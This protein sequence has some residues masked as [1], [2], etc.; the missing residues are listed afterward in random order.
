MLKAD[1]W[2]SRA[3]SLTSIAVL[4]GLVCSVFINSNIV[5]SIAV[6]VVAVFIFKVAVDIFRPAVNQLLDG[7]ADQK[8]QDK[9]IEIAES[10]EG[11]IRVDEI[12]TR[13][14]GNAI[15]ADLEIHVDGS[16]SV[17]QGH[18]IAEEVHDKLETSSELRIKHCNVHVNPCKGHTM[19]HE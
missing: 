11:V 14:F 15:L 1:A 8:D 16:L 6:L 4:I 5:E 10:V 9:I 3:D 2:H 7:A 19:K 17:E 13:I 18:S 12:R